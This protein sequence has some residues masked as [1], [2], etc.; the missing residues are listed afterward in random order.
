MLNP[1]TSTLV[2]PPFP[3]VSCAS[4]APPCAQSRLARPSLAHIRAAQ[5]PWH[6]AVVV[7]VWVTTGEGMVAVD[8]G[9]RRI[10]FAISYLVWSVELSTSP[11]L[12]S[13]AKNSSNLAK[14]DRN[15]RTIH[16]SES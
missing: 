6:C 16:S 15:T 9:L 13:G 3:Y 7:V 4:A 2:S 5:P 14:P 12:Q 8:L 10:D 1:T 11:K